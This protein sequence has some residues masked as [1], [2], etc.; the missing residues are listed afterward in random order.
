LGLKESE[1]AKRIE[2][3]K[4]GLRWSGGFF[5]HENDFLVP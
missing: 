1:A 4:S 3:W 5:E 2:V